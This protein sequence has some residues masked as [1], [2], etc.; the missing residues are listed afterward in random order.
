MYEAHS[1]TTAMPVGGE[2]K[3]LCE[4]TRRDSVRKQKNEGRSC[5]RQEVGNDIG[6]VK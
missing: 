6:K 3:L 2:R 5:E 1:G 4:I